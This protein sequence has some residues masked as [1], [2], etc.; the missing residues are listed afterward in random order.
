MIKEILLNR[1]DIKLKII[2][3]GFWYSL[4]NVS[5]IVL[6]L[7]KLYIMGKIFEPHTFGVYS[8]TLMIMTLITSF[9]TT[10]AKDYLIRSVNPSESAVTT[11]FT[12]DFF[13]G[14]IA[15]SVMLVLSN[16]LSV[17]YEE[18]V[19]RNYLLL[20]SISFLAGAF[21][22][23]NIYKLYVNFEA[24]KAVVVMQL[25]II[26][27]NILTIVFAV[28]YKSI[29]IIIL[30]NVVTELLI[31]I[32]SYIYSFRAPRVKIYKEEIKNQFSFSLQLYFL[33]VLSYVLRQ[34]DYYFVSV[35]FDLAILG[36]YT[37]GYRIINIV[38]DSLLPIITN[39]FYPLISKSTQEKK[40]EYTSI[41]INWIT[42]FFIVFGLNVYF[43]MDE[44]IKVLFNSKWNGLYELLVS[45]VAYS[46]I[47]TL[48]SILGILYKVNNHIKYDNIACIVEFIVI[49]ITIFPLVYF[50]DIY[51]VVYAITI[52]LLVRLLF[53]AYLSNKLYQLNML[54][55]VNYKAFTLYFLANLGV[56]L[57]IN[58]T[59]SS[60]NIGAT[61]ISI[62]LS[63]VSAC[64]IFILMYKTGY[65]SKA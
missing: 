34:M 8:I 54:K 10:G 31:T 13:R 22:N 6:G 16:P 23:I 36:F 55:S 39:I 2:H 64:L 19:L 20:M 40:N 3:A 43:Y 50:Y 56:N 58:A 27:T 17:F 53:L 11:A 44:L 47:R 37:L 18:P 49:S 14:I 15:F 25:P 46:L 4:G 24:K 52:A 51:G 62:M 28:I 5:N 57:I 60:S 65:I 30:L 1:N 9:T 26:I 45:L 35:Y 21:R 32:F 48:S 38:P 12:M 29:F 7:V 41:L 33:V 63:L 59:I 61:V 42:I